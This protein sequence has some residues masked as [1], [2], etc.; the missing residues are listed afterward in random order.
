MIK[1]RLIKNYMCIILV[2]LS[3]LLFDS[4]TMVTT[5][6]IDNDTVANNIVASPALKDFGS[7]GNESRSF[8]AVVTNNDEASTFTA[9]AQGKGNDFISFEPSSFNL[10]KGE[11]KEVTVKI[12]NSEKLGVGPYDLSIIFKAN[13]NEKEWI[14]ARTANSIRLRFIKEGISVASFNVTDVEKP[15]T[16]AFHIIFSNFTNSKQVMDTL[17]TILTK[18][19]N[20][21]IQQFKE[22]VNMNAYPSDGF[23][24]TMKIAWPT[25]NMEMGE[26]ILRYNAISSDGTTLQGEKTFKIGVMKGNLTKVEVKDTRKGNDAQ[27]IA[28]VENVG[29]LDLPVSF[30]VVIKDKSGNVVFEDKKQVTITTG[31]DEDMVINWETSTAEIGK[32][33]AE[34]TVIMGKDTVTNTLSFKILIPYVD[35]VVAFGIL[36]LIFVIIVIF[37]RMIY[38]KFKH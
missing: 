26:Y 13:N 36:I 38:N 9:E 24:G 27:V 10:E 23:Y 3:F 12:N 37:K 32:Y 25:E 14:S 34:Y 29:N 19:D 11:S 33:T 8:T 16:T 28:H 4:F 7:I 18:E 35:Y 31:S 15:N 20:R 17:V 30:N 6:A 21:T 22:P 5:K 2:F 1:S